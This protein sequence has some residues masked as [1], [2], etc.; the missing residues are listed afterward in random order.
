MRAFTKE[1]IRDIIISILAVTLIFSFPD[2]RDT[3][4]TL[5]IVVVLSFFIHEM[6]HKLMARRLGCMATYKLW[7]V[8]ILFG[9]VSMFLKVIGGFV[10]IA[11]GYVEIMPY[12]FGRWGLRVIRL[13]PRDMGLIAL[14]GVGV[15]VFFAV[16]F[17]FFT[18]G[19]FRTLSHMNAVLSIFN[20]LPVPPLDGVKIFTWNMWLWLFLFL[21]SG[22]I[23]IAL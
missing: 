12:T 20:L 16:F 17:S 1:E 23:L 7:P 4:F 22:I 11:P 15:N 3:F 13:T 5:F 8:G 18:G 14:A 6:G 10:I 9:L 21:T 19:F 2:L